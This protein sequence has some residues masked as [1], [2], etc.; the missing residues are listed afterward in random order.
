MSFLLFWVSCFDMVGCFQALAC[1]RKLISGSRFLSGSRGPFSK[2]LIWNKPC[3]RFDKAPRW[4]SFAANY[5]YRKEKYILWKP[6]YL[7]AF[8]GFIIYLHEKAFPDSAGDRKTYAIMHQPHSIS[9]SPSFLLLQSA[10]VSTF[11]KYFSLKEMNQKKIRCRRKTRWPDEW[12][13]ESSIS[14]NNIHV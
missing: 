9:S 10:N 7:S 11:V 12:E 6:G 2:Y 5:Q 3:L 4:R 8:A 1:E 14:T 13:S